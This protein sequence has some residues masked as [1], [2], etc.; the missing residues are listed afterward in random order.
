L[1]V[2]T[3]EKVLGKTWEFLEQDKAFFF[4]F[5]VEPVLNKLEKSKP[6][7][8]RVL[9]SQ[10]DGAQTTLTAFKKWPPLPCPRPQPRCRRFP[11]HR[12][13]AA[14]PSS[15][16]APGGYKGR[17]PPPWSILFSSSAFHP[18]CTT[19]PS[20]A[21]LPQVARSDLSPTDLTTP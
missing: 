9:V 4:D 7:R 17:P 11:A 5:H 14:T 10:T 20:A 2:G 13:L 16:T 12:F 6:R 8:P 19:I 21:E 3:I 1:D 18:H 15:S